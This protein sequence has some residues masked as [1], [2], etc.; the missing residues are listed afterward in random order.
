MV[1]M[2]WII[3]TLYLIHA[4][5]KRKHKHKGAENF[6]ACLSWSKFSPTVKLTKAIE[7]KF[8]LTVKAKKLK[9]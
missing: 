3:I 6:L 4:K 2:Y 5:K 8:N 7:V 1:Y 9:L